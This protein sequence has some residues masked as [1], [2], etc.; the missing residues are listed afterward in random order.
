[1]NSMRLVRTSLALMIAIALALLPVG[2]SAAGLGR[3]SDQAATMHMGSSDDMSAVMA[4]DDC[5]PDTKAKP[6]DHDGG[7]CP[8]CFC[9]APC[10]GLANIASLRFEFP[11]IRRN[12]ILI[13]SDQVASLL[14]ASPPFRPPRV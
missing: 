11:A 10:V 8:L 12:A 14:G 6:H 5:C 2:A 4:M 13:P 1:M 3:M 7:K 9:A